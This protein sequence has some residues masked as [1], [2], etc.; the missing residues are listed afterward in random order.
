V[1][2]DGFFLRPRVDGRKKES[3]QHNPNELSIMAPL[4]RAESPRRRTLPRSR[5]S[6]CQ[7]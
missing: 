6:P 4:G 3:G 5:S 7:R 1:V 2:I